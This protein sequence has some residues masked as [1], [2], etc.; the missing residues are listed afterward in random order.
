MIGL[1]TAKKGVGITRFW[2]LR[3]AAKTCELFPAIPGVETK[4]PLSYNSLMTVAG[5]RHERIAGEIRQ[6]ISAMLAGELKDPRV[7]AFATV[8]EVRMTPDLKQAKIY[9]SVMG[10]AAEQASTIKGLSAAAGFIRHELSERL[11]L[12]RA[13]E[14]MFVLD[15]SEEYGQ[16]IDE[17]LR[18]T[19]SSAD[20]D[21]HNP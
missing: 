14:L 6:E 19:K 20:P 5:H 15:R 10:T 18:R 12:R 2:R 8:T 7:V 17:L 1:S 3:K 13:P 9:V 11:Q 4:P 21:R 16:R